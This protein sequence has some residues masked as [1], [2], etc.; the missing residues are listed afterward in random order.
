MRKC[1]LNTALVIL[2]GSF[3]GYE[4]R[5]TAAHKVDSILQSQKGIIG[6]LAQALLTDTAQPKEEAI[7]RVDK[8][9]QK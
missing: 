3:A 1:L 8:A 9:F 7:E 5:D 6:E 4:Q 2:L